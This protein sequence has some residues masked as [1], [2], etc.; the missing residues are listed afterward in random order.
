[1]RF[2]TNKEFMDAVISGRKF[3]Y[4]GHIYCYDDT[5]PNPFRIGDANLN[6]YWIRILTVDFEEISNAPLFP[7]G[8]PV[9]CWNTTSLSPN[10]RRFDAINNRAFSYEGTRQGVE[11]KN[12]KEFKGELPYELPKIK[13]NNE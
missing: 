2:K 7:D 4:D 12:Y 10:L 11:W 13:E 3:K 1:M 6:F 8:T 9:W 5:E